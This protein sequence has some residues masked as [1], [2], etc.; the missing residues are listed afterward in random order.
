MHADFFYFGENIFL[1]VV[2]SYSKWIEFEYTRYGTDT[3]MVIKKFLNIFARFGLPDVLVTNG[4]PPFNGLAF[5]DFMKRQGI[6]VLKSPPYHPASNGQAERTVR[7]VKEVFKKFLLDSQ[8]KIQDVEEQLCYF[9]LNYRNSCLTKTGKFSS[10]HLYSYKPKTLLDLMNPTNHYKNYLVPHHQ[11]STKV[12]NPELD[13]VVS[14]VD[15]FNHLIPSD[16]LWYRN[17]RPKDAQR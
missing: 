7:T 16:K 15:N 1:L 11:D 12:K 17:H 4:R 5:V 14:Q 6:I 3:K 8:R 2:D 9:L 10:E 13:R